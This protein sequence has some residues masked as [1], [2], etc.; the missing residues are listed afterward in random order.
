[1]T[2]GN[3][4]ATDELVSKARHYWKIKGGRFTP[5]R[6]TVCRIVATK[7]SAFDVEALWDEAQA[8]D[9]RISISAL[10]RIVA[11]L[12]EAN[13]IREIHNSGGR[14]TFVTTSFAS[15]DA[16]HLRCRNCG[17]IVPVRDPH[18]DE[19]IKAVAGD[20]GFKT[21]RLFL[22]VQ[23]ECRSCGISVP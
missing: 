13:L 15:A 9:R 2:R 23:A 4:P 18:L 11:D 3:N 12:L 6:E 21:E 10:Y 8:V 22:H 7:E 16:A 5:A 19:V 17:K 14:R 20:H 1:M